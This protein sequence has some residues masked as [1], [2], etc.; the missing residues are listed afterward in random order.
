MVLQKALVMRSEGMELQRSGQKTVNANT[1][2]NLG[3]VQNLK[4]RQVRQFTLALY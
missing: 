3:R 1:V 2:I 4:R